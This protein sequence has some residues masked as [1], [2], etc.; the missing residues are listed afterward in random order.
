MPAAGHGAHHGERR[1]RR[2]AG[3]RGA[4]HRRHPPDRRPRPPGRPAGAVPARRPRAAGR[5]R[6]PR[7]APGRG[8]P[9]PADGGARARRRRRAGRPGAGAGGGGDPARPHCGRTVPGRRPG[10]R[11]GDRPARPGRRQPGHPRSGRRSC[12]AGTPTR[13]PARLQ[14]RYGCPAILEND[15]NLRALGEARALP[16]DQ[17]P[18]LF[19]KVGTGIGGGLVSREGVLHHGADGAAGDIGHVRVRGAPDDPCVCGNVGCIEA[20]ASAVGHRAAAGRRP[21][22][23]VPRSPSPTCGPCSPAADPTARGLVRE[24]AAPDRRGRGHA[25]ALLQPGPGDHRRL[26]HRGQRRAARRRAQRRLPARAAAGHPQPGA[27]QQRR[28]AS[29]P[30]WPGLR[31][32][33]SSR[34]SR[35]RRS[36]R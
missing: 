3:P 26:P 6:R 4:A 15:V 21:P 18:L 12:P 35:P 24:A 30:G 11:G 5:R 36:A 22:A 9:E 17:A 20:V 16:A 7:R 28:W 13:C 8:R 1:G 19:V 23:A 33:A 31:C 14:Q 10:A 25:G 27:G 32:W 34:P 2:A 29:T